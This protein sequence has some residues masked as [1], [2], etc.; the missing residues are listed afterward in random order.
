MRVPLSWLRD[1]VALEMPLAELA[2]RLA[3]STAEVEP[4]EPRG[5]PDADGNLGRSH[6][7][8]PCSRA[9]TSS[10]GASSAARYPRG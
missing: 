6:S 10:N 7:T 1:Y 9:D 4:I 2:E 8:A 5:V 3:I